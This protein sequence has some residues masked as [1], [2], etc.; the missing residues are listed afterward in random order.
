MTRS[1][2]LGAIFALP[3]MIAGASSAQANVIA[4]NLDASSSI[5][6]AD[7]LLQRQGYI[8][9]LTNLLQP[10]GKNSIAVYQFSNNV[11]Q[12]FAMRT[13]STAQDKTDLITALTNFT[14]ISG[15]TAIGSS[16]NTAVAAITGFT[17]TCLVGAPHCI[18]D[19]STDGMNNFGADLPSAI[20]AA[21]AAGIVV[22]CLGV[23]AG[24]GCLWNG[25]G[26]DWAAA[27]FTQFNAAIHSKL[28]AELGVPEPMTVTLFGAGLAG[29]AFM[30]RRRAKKA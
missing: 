25:T 2:L 3:L 30:R 22:N 14:R 23:G 1:K 13:I 17:N 15:Q 9:A 21:N 20:T 4:L 18:I 8:N 5:S 7:F 27:D 29:A 16:V 24:S 19:V 12:V 10:D 6:G 11:T 28:S 26:L